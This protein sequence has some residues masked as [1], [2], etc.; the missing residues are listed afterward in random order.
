MKFLSSV[1]SRVRNQINFEGVYGA[2]LGVRRLRRAG[3]MGC[4]RASSP[5]EPSSKE[6]RMSTSKFSISY[7]R[8]DRAESRW[9]YKFVCGVLYIVEM[10]Q[11]SIISVIIDFEVVKDWWPPSV[12][13]SNKQRGQ[14]PSWSKIYKSKISS[15]SSSTHRTF[16]SA[17]RCLLLGPWAQIITHRSEK[18]MI[19]LSIDSGKN[20]NV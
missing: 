11:W 19:W 17:D 16:S 20:F 4:L 6:I 3:G 10:Y 5:S 15:L 13:V 18:Y 7:L 12:N 8:W 1:Y 9:K 2:Q 14:S